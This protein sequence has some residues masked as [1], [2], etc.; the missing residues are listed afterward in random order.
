VSSDQPAAR[1]ATRLAFLVNGF[2]IGCWAPLVPF[3]K[4]RLAVDDGVLGVL[5]LCIGLGSIVAMLL[6]GPLSARYGSKPIIVA[7]G[8]G[9]AVVLPLLV[10][11]GTPLTLGLS[12]LAFGASLGSLD[13]AM[14]VH[15]VEVERVADRPLMSGFHGLF[16]VGGFAGSTLMTFLLSIHTGMLA[17]TLLC[18]VLMFAAMAATRPRLLRVGQSSGVP[19]FAIPRGIILVLSVLAAIAFLTEGAL[20][21]WSALLV[22]DKALVAA[23]HSGLGY[24]LFSIAMTA[25]R[26]GGDSIT[27]RIGDRSIM[28]WGGTLAVLGFV[29]L[30]VV[31]I[32]TLAMTGFLLIGLGISNVVP[33]LYRQAGS[34]RTMPPALA[35]GA[36]AIIGY[37]G[38]L[39][40]PAA[41]GFAAKFIGLQNAFWALVALLC[42]VPCCARLA[43]TSRP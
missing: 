22:A 23:T 35:I 38:I 13:V 5:L 18:A 12:L 33:V 36:M 9:A 29:T 6:T 20:L 31:P 40:G 27:S 28:F 21:D 34:Q 32:P 37:V 3:A 41:V 14:N 16:S 42:L 25:G 8:I 2:G 24:I 10:I 1:L 15:A 17:S 19:V 39:A 11:A 43:T 26:L 4:Q 7:G 30:L